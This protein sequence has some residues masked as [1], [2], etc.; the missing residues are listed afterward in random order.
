MY[1]KIFNLHNISEKFTLQKTVILIMF[2]VFLALTIGFNITAA[3]ILNRTAIQRAQDSITG[4]AAFAGN[5]IKSYSKYMLNITKDWAGRDD[6]YD[7]LLGSDGGL[8]D[9]VL[10]CSPSELYGMDFIVITDADD[11]VVYEYY[12]NSVNKYKPKE[13]LPLSS[14]IKRISLEVKDSFFGNI[15]F[16]ISDETK[17]GMS[18]LANLEDKI[19]YLSSYPITKSDGMD[20]FAGILTFG[21]LVDYEELSKTVSGYISSI[22]LDSKLNLCDEDLKILHNE[23]ILVDIDIKNEVSGAWLLIDDIFSEPSIIITVE[24]FFAEG[25]DGIFF[26]IILASTVTLLLIILL[27]YYFIN[28]HI[29]NPLKILDFQVKSIKDGKIENISPSQLKWKEF[30]FLGNAVFDMIAGM[31]DRTKE[32]E[33]INDSFC[34]SSQIVNSTTDEILLFD[35]DGVLEFINPSALKNMGY[36]LNLLKGKNIS[37]IIAP[38]QN[39]FFNKVISLV[40]SNISWHGD[41]LF[42]NFDGECTVNAAS[43]SPVVSDNSDPERFIL[44]KRNMEDAKQY[45][46]Q[47]NH[48]EHHDILTGLPNRIFF[49][50]KLTEA[51]EEAKEKGTKVAIFYIDIDRF[52]Y[53]NDTLGH[54]VGDKLIKL[55]SM[56]FKNNFFDRFFVARMGGDE[57]SI[58]YTGITDLSEVEKVANKIS[59]MLSKPFNIEDEECNLSASIGSSIYPDNSSEIEILI[60]N[61]DEAMYNAKHLGRNQYC[62]FSHKIH[63][64]II[65]RVSLENNLRMAVANG[66]KDFV[67][68]FQPKVDSK[69]KRIIGAEALI[70]WITPNGIIRPNEF[71]PMAEE[72]GTIVPI[73][74]YMLIEACKY[75]RKFYEQGID[76]AVSVNISSKVILDE[77]FVSM[78][79]DAVQISGMEPGKLDIEITEGTLMADVEKVNIVLEKIKNMGVTITVDDFGTGYSSLIYLK[80]FFV[81]RLKIDKAFITGISENSDDLALV[82][83]ILAMAKT[84]KILVTAEGVETKTQFKLLTA[85]NCEEIQGFY[86]SEPIPFVQFCVFAKNWPNNQI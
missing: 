35:K 57:F 53:I 51:I 3:S 11:K 31:N 58:I 7:C 63:D 70:R 39:N 26:T 5:L 85:L 8:S 43:I 83:A 25:G 49:F 46:M 21:K 52:K 20:L 14:L 41:L 81:D 10:G 76:V 73:S 45:E 37:T 77:N 22:R 82:N 32:I 80:K 27:L 86:I 42:K 19:Y 60:K 15:L 72:T 2:I 47:I 18:G 28:R 34:I 78:V 65:R 44:I 74:R 59:L 6:L 29:L 4:Q 48:I 50:K 62:S 55:I 71:I 84:L 64:D 23:G 56:R 38:Q 1:K 40:H 13:G 66:C 67:P 69:S 61:A 75:N 36:D 68:Y 16:N 9:R 17:I 54:G 79:E 33:D 24:G 12:H 30:S